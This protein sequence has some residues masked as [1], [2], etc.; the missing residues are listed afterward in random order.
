MTEGFMD[1]YVFEES[2]LPTGFRFPIGYL[3]IMKGPELPCLTPW[4]FIGK[5]T[6]TARFWLATL[7]E[8]YPLRLLIPFAKRDDWSDTL[9]AFDGADHSGNP[10]VFH[11]HAFTPPGWEERGTWRS[12]EEWLDQA[13]QDAAE[14]KAEDEGA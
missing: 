8:Q 11:I 13:R 6:Q 7:Q 9:A 2:L 5:R 4:W 3:N 1:R 10:A 14:F 12:F